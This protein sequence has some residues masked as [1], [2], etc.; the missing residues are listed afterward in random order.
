MQPFS[1]LREDGPPRLSVMT[2]ISRLQRWKSMQRLRRKLRWRN[3]APGSTTS[4]SHA[5]LGGRPGTS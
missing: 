5:S 3:F 2:T 4:V 1:T